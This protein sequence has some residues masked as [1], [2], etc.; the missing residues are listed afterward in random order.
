MMNLGKLKVYYTIEQEVC[1]IFFLKKTRSL[2]M[3]VYVYKN[4]N[5]NRYLVKS[6]GIIPKI[7]IYLKIGLSC[8]QKNTEPLT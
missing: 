7:T 4:I 8:K 5:I 2:Y 1:I 3:R 6:L